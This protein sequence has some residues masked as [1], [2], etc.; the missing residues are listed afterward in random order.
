MCR[1][2][3][4][5][6]SATNFSAEPL[7]R[8]AFLAGASAIALGLA[9]PILRFPAR[10]EEEY[11]L[12]LR[13]ADTGEDTFERFSLDGKS[14]YNRGY[15]RLCAALRDNHVPPVRGDVYISI[16]LIELLWAVQQV[17][18]NEGVHEPIVVHSGYRTPET[19]AA[20]EGAA[21]NSLHMYGM[22]ID[23]DV[24]GVAIDELA[25]L[26]WNCPGSGGVGSYAGGWVHLDTGERRFWTG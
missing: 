25:D 24:P 4:S 13:R 22:A 18:L 1:A 15:Y 10:A 5:L 23:F 14:V 12:W 6:A 7:R 20:T 2:C 3:A 21:T 11:V 8:R 17:L 9:I 26:C 19:N 16:R